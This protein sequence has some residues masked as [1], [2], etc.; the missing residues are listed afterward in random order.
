MRLIQ[1][2]APPE[3]RRVGLIEDDTVFDL[4]KLN[5]AWDRIYNI[6]FEASRKATTIEA[7]ITGCDFRSA[8]AAL[9]Y[10]ELLN[11]H[12]GDSAGWILPPLDHPDPAHS[13]ITV[14]GLT[15]LGSTSQRDQM[16][17]DDSKPQTD[18][19]KMFE[20][21]L[22]G[23]KPVTG[24]RGVQPECFQKGTGAI[25][26]GHNDFLDI[27][28]FTEDGGEEPEIVGCYI[29]DDDGI[30]CRLG[31]AVGNEWSDH[32]MEQ[33]NYLWL[34]HSKQRVCSIGPELTTD[35]PFK[36]VRGGCRITRGKE[37][38]YD[39][40]ELLT[41]ESNMNHSLANIEDHL[42]KYPQSCVPGDIHIFFFGTMKFSFGER[43]PLQDGDRIEI[44]FD[45][46]GGSLVN[47]VR[48]LPQESKPV[49]VRKG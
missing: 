31:F 7:Y 19:Q 13:I 37:V 18:S 45:S 44:R 15:H 39:S 8:T 1:F 9:S 48:R 21:G 40:G 14:T 6:F 38:L 11:R 33:V 29:I 46:F 16:H 35:H 2:Q 43:G 47:W 30:P 12:P 27:P 3:G 34:G 41:G 10:S 23:G 4:T 20:M 42:F 32:A 22:K 17:R 36:D 24:V 49:R 26:R 25:L 28:S 5:P